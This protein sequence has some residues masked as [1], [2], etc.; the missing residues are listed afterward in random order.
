MGF[1]LVSGLAQ[2]VGI[3][4]VLHV[5]GKLVFMCALCKSSILYPFYFCLPQN[6]STETLE[7]RRVG[8]GG[9]VRVGGLGGV[10]ENRLL[11]SRSS[12]VI[13]R[14]SHHRSARTAQ[15][16]NLPAV[17]LTQQPQICR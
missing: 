11:P 2:L 5:M 15:L 7:G 6:L 3:L 13:H 17:D 16:P 14:Q 4:L 12:D 10:L 8:W 1:E 9:R